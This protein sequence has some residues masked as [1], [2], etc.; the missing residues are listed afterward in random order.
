M[1]TPL[2]TLTKAQRRE[3]LADFGATV[4][5]LMERHKD[6]GADLLEGISLHAMEASLATTSKAGYFVRTKPTKG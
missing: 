1:S 4:L 6:W 2:E 5:L 3:R